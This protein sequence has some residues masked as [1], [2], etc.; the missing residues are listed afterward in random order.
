MEA[1]E[2]LNPAAVKS[3][4]ADSIVSPV[5]SGTVAAPGMS[6]GLRQAHG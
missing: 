3:S 1:T 4:V 2:R 6:S 5:T